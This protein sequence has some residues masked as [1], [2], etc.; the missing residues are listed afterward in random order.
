MQQPAKA[1]REYLKNAVMTATPEQLH[2][3]LLDGAIRFSLRGRDALERRDYEAAFQAFDRAQRI[4]LELTNG[5]RRDVNPAVADQMGALHNFVF[6][7]L[8]D[9]NTQHDLNAVDEAVRILRHQ[10]ETWDLVIDKLARD[11]APGTPPPAV[12]VTTPAATAP[13]S[14]FTSEPPRGAASL[15]IEA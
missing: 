12:A 5:L 15:S 4:C 14:K 8:V 3:M 2:V 11:T 1:A 6:R 7:R 10:R 9:A 13:A